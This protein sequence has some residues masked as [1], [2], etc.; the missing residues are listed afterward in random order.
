MARASNTH[1]AS[2]LLVLACATRAGAA[3]VMDALDI[4]KPY[5][6]QEKYMTNGFHPTSTWSY[7]T[8]D[9]RVQLGLVLSEEPVQA[10][11]EDAEDWHKT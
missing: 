11:C 4:K 3:G 2:L 5:P 1:R 6:Q 8:D 9:G 7:K 10:S